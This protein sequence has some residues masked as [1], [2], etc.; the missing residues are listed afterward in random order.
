VG[1]D[2]DF[3]HQQEN[4]YSASVEAPNGNDFFDD[5]QLGRTKSYTKAVSIL[6]KFSD[7][8]AL[9]L[10]TMRDFEL[11]EMQYLDPGNDALREMW[12]AYY[13]SISDDVS[14]MRYLRRLLIHRIQTFDRMKDG[15]GDPAVVFLDPAHVRLQLVN[16]SALKESRYSTKQGDDIGV[17]TNMTV[18]S[19]QTT[20]VE[21]RQMS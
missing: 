3:E 4:A 1:A 5:A 11:G 7:T 17:L 6:K 2:L 10:D 19:H 13:D 15:V 21:C 12:N 8:L 18:V 16:A 9:T 20:V 14:I